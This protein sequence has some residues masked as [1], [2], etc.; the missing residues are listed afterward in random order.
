MRK[1]NGFILIFQ[2]FAIFTTIIILLFY[3]LV[4]AFNSEIEVNTEIDKYNEFIGPNAIKEYKDKWGMDETIFP[5]KITSNMNVKDYKMVYYNPWDAEY[6]SYL[7]VE[8]NE[9]D[10]KNEVKRLQEYE[11]TEYIGIYTV[12]G[13]SKYKLLAMYADTYNGFVYAITDNENTIIY[14]ELIL[15]DYNYDFDYTKYIKE[16]Y[17]PDGFDAIEDNKYQMDNLYEH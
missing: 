15:C 2:L 17:L 8:Y 16:E 3:F 10:Y 7:V 1:E 12:T 4:I 14:V 13:F 11:S 6:L 5:K 9:E